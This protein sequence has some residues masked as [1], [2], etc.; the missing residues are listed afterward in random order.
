MSINVEHLVAA[1]D[2]PEPAGVDCGGA[3]QGANLQLLADYLAARAIRRVRER[4]I[5]DTAD[6]ES[7]QYDG[8][9]L[10]EASRRVANLE[11]EVRAILQVASVNEALVAAHIREQAASQLGT[12]GK[13]LR[14]VVY[15]C[16][17]AIQEEGIAGFC[18]CVDL[19]VALLDRHGASLHPRPDEDAPDDFWAWGVALGRLIAGD[20]N[21]AMLTDTVVF[22][23]RLTGRLTLDDLAGGLGTGLPFKPPAVGDV[24]AVIAECGEVRAG[25]VLAL[26][27]RAAATLSAL[28]AAVDPS[29]LD[30]NPLGPKF[31]A[32]AEV[33]RGVL[34][35]V[36]AGTAE[37]PM[38]SG[39]D[40]GEPAHEVRSDVPVVRAMP[41]VGPPDT[42][43]APR[44]REEVRRMLRQLIDVMEASE[45]GHPAPLLM[46]RAERLL[47]K[48]FLDI[49]RDLSPGS[50]SDIE[51]IA[52][53]EQEE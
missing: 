49:I 6:E 24:D 28:M 16:A 41:V 45:P 21:M 40:D 29:V 4:G 19:A 8:V 15:L 51:R 30:S 42:S 39:E 14:C 37:A 46:R 38:A 11:K 18:D 3:L 27:E 34:Q 26:C 1:I 2:G 48:N 23:G 43:S 25:E 20:V 47:G 36:G 35:R 33:V 10:E 17:A 50:L 32:A 7:A 5:D 12:T 44:T 53:L 22:Q 13:D 31:L 52:G 9:M